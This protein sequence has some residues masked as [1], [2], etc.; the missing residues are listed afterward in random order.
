MNKCRCCGN[1]TIQEYDEFE[2]CSVCGWEDDDIQYADPDFSGGAN[3]LSLNE[4]KE[5]LKI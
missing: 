1:A 4:Y 2:I 3:E 5:R